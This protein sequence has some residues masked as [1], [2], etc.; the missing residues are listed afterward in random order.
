MILDGSA[1]LTTPGVVNTAGETIATTLSVTGVTTLTGGFTVGA[2]AVP[3]FSAYQGTEQSVSSGVFTKIAFT[4][5]N[6][7]TANCFDSTTN[8]RFTPNVAGYY[9]I[10]LLVYGSGTTM[11][12]LQGAIYK[13]GVNISNTLSAAQSGANCNAMNSVLVYMNG[14]TDYI[15][16][17]GS[18]LSSSSPKLGLTGYPNFL[19][20]SGYLAR[21]A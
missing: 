10:N 4:V 8:Y 18:N 21:S 11:S 2:T 17:Y 6:F 13:N 3:A 16:G 7:D 19:I 20:I 14:S 9:Q 15:E 5:E 1:G 12:Y